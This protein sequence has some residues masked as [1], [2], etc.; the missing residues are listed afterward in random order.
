MLNIEQVAGVSR[1]F[2]GAGQIRKPGN[3]RCRLAADWGTR[4]LPSGDALHRVGEVTVD[5]AE[6]VRTLL[7]DAKYRASRRILEPVSLRSPVPAVSPL[8]LAALVLA[9]FFAGAVAALGGG[10]GPTIAPAPP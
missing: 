8:E 2:A 10:G 1:G 7:H 5:L 4:E 3:P 6:E 9:A